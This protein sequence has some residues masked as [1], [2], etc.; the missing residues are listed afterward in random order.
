MCFDQTS[1]DAN[2]ECGGTHITFAWR[3]EKTIDLEG[4]VDEM[5]E[6]P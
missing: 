1:S 4:Y 5:D 3:Y 2:N 6:L